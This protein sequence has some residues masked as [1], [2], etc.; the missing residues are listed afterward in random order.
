MEGRSGGATGG[1]FGSVKPPL[2]GGKRS[3]P[4][5]KTTTHNVFADVSPTKAG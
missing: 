2:T 3:R 4:S 5:K 1:P